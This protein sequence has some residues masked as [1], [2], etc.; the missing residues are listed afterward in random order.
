MGGNT[1]DIVADP[2]QILSSENLAWCTAAWYWKVN[3][4]DD[5][6]PCDLGMTIDAINGKEECASHAN[7]ESHSE[8]SKNRYCYFKKFYEEYSG[9][10][11]KSW[12]VGTACGNL[13][14]QSC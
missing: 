3:V 5:R 13:Y 8:E 14:K 10:N 4:Q 12:H 9:S 6:C 11:V 1:V 2:D 7:K